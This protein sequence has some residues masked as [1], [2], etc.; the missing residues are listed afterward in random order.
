MLSTAAVVAVFAMVSVVARV[1][2]KLDQRSQQTLCVG[3]LQGEFDRHIAQLVI[4]SVD[5]DT[6]TMR[7]EQDD[8]RG[9]VVR[10]EHIGQECPGE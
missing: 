4:A 3:N 10:L 8:L 6:A 7:A 5:R 9:V 2:H 1:Q